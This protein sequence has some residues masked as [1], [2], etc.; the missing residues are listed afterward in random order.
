ME[1]EASP[2]K[3]ADETVN[4][5]NTVTV[6]PTGVSVDV[7]HDK[8]TDEPS[9]EQTKEQVKDGIHSAQS[10][11]VLKPYAQTLNPRLSSK[12]IIF[13]SGTGHNQQ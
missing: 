10:H 7:E 2:S 5:D 12:S 1:G 9:A 3:I 8:H 11:K 4:L 6:D 13:L